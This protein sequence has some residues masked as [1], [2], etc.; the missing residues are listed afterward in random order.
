M[1][2]IFIILVTMI[3][4]TVSLFTPGIAFSVSADEESK[5]TE[6]V[7]RSVKTVITS[8]DELDGV[9]VMGAEEKAVLTDI[10]TDFL[11]FSKR[12]AA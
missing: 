3:I 8:I 12:S 10:F 2:R 4:M 1:K 9:I 7:K 5:T 11:M 6:D